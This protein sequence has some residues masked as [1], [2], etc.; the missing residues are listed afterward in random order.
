M[1]TQTRQ[2]RVRGTVLVTRPNEMSSTKRGEKSTSTSSSQNY[3]SKHRLCESVVK[4]VPGKSSFY[5]DIMEFFENFLC[6]TMINP[7]LFFRHTISPFSRLKHQFSGSR[8]ETVINQTTWTRLEI[9]DTQKNNSRH[10][11]PCSTR[12]PRPKRQG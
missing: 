5:F 1:T 8:I 9:E 6:K 4:G 7:F 2:Q 10:L 3:G 11:T 12:G